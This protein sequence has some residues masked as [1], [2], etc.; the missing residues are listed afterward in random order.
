MISGNKKWLETKVVV[1]NITRGLPVAQVILKEQEVE[2]LDVVIDTSALLILLGLCKKGLQAILRDHQGWGDVFLYC[3]QE[4]LS[5]LPL[6]ST[7][8]RLF[9]KFLW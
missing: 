2:F 4:L 8:L 1:F 7:P 3:R 6:T 9:S 5:R